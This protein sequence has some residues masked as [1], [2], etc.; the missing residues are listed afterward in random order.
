MSAETPFTKPHWDTTRL[1]GRK[2]LMMFG[3]VKIWNSGE[4][5]ASGKASGL[6]SGR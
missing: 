4:T 3:A 2:L 1:R 6:K 5:M